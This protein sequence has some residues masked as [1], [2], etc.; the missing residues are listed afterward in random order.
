[1]TTTVRGR[2]DSTAGRSTRNTVGIVQATVGSCVLIGSMSFAVVPMA[3]AGTTF[4]APKAFV[5]NKD[6]AKGPCIRH[7][8]KS[9]VQAFTADEGKSEPLVRKGE[10][11]LR[12]FDVESGSVKF[13]EVERAFGKGVETKLQDLYVLLDGQREGEIG[14]LLTEANKSNFFFIRDRGNQLRVVSAEFESDGH[15][16]GNWRL[17]VFRLYDTEGCVKGSRVFTRGVP[18]TQSAMA[19][20]PQLEPAM[21]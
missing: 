11:E 9:F 8:G 10:A 18:I 12:G 15:G 5:E 6:P 7:L 13:E 20:E 3:L 16:G 14:P 2:K 19:T 21:A 17:C 1:M 4:C